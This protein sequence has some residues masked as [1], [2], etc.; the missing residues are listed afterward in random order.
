MTGD[1]SPRRSETAERILDL[2][3]QLIQTRGFSAFSYQDIADAL[4]VTKASIHYHFASKGDLGV[5]VVERYS[6]R[7]DEALR[8]M[9]ANDAMP[10]AAM[11]E[12][13]CDPF[14]QLSRTQDRVCLCG[15]L[16]G[17]ILVLPAEMRA[18]VKRFF[19]SLQL[20]LEK[21]LVR[22]SS[23][24]ELSLPGPAPQVARLAF[25]ALQGALLVRRATG[26]ASE[27]EDVISVLKSVLQRA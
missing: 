3:E 19:R 11:L 1:A 23:R 6:R 27:A 5:A 2:A 22:G 18:S 12:A 24:G 26:D 25:A 10:T 20:W 17:E 4:G 15:A 14:R 8:S 13:Y 16:A 9:T 21:L 7:F